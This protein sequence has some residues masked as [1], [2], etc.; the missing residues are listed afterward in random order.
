MLQSYR[1][2]NAEEMPALEMTVEASELFKAHWQRYC[3]GFNPDFSAFPARHTE[4]AVRL[5]LVLHAWG[6]VNFGDD[7]AG[8][9][10]ARCDAETLPLSGDTARR[11]LSVAAWFEAQQ[12]A[13]LAPMREAAGV[14]KFER[15]FA[16]CERRR[17]WVVTSRDLIG[18]RIA[19]TAEEADK[20]LATWE[21]EGRAVR[22]QI[23]SKPGAGA[24]PTKPRFRIVRRAGARG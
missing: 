20:L 9:T 18:A 14:E 1:E 5:A 13:M 22:E 23:E 4:N 16:R 2:R 8:G 7:G 6:A 21:H 24:K 11:A 10:V 17:E 15:V 3:D 12:G 19:D